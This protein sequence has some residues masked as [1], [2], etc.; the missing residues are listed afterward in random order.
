MAAAVASR[1]ALPVHKSFP[2]ALQRQR[3]ACPVG[4]LAHRAGGR[5][6]LVC[7]AASSQPSSSGSQSADSDPLS[8]NEPASILQMILDNQAEQ[9]KTLSAL[10]DSQKTIRGKLEV[11]DQMISAFEESLGTIRGKLEARDQMISALEELLEKWTEDMKDA[12]DALE[13][14]QANQARQ[15]EELAA[16]MDNYN[17][18]KGS[19]SGEGEELRR[20]GENSTGDED[21]KGP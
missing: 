19:L 11:R 12:E 7:K 15:I 6:L 4:R 21:L 14:V 16:L 20:G 1:L 2:S 18:L 9:A 13:A 8:C 17:L 5:Q 10:E 3:R